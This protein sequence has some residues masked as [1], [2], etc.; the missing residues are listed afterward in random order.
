MWPRPS[1]AGENMVGATTG[2]HAMLVKL[3][4]ISLHDLALH[5]KQMQSLIKITSG[6]V[7]HQQTNGNDLVSISDI[8]NG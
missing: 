2:E 5:L 1:M 6:D 8:R 3:I 7:R 4:T